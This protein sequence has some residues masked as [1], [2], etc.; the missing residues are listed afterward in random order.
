MILPHRG[1]WPKVHETAFIAPSA[2]VIG[3]VELGGNSSIWFQCVVRGDVNTIRIGNRTNI[4]DQ[5]V[6]HVTRVKS[7]LT[8]GNDVTVGHRAV[9]HGCTI[10]DRVLVGMGAIIMDDVKVEDDCLI[11]AGALITPGTHVPTRSLVLGSPAKVVRPLREEEIAF[12]SKSAENYVQ[13]SR[14]YQGY[15]RGPRRMG[16]EPSELEEFDDFEGDR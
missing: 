13:D 16:D 8:I 6:L 11:G 7:R 3:D 15:V 1:R 2:D 5:S 14:E 12:L 9:L 10:G 4:Q